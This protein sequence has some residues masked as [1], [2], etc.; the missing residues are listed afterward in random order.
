MEM[1][2]MLKYSENRKEKIHDMILESDNLIS[3]PNF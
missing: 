2:L 3:V 1:I